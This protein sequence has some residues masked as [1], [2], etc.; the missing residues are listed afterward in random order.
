[1]EKR[2]FATL[3]FLVVI[4]VGVYAA[5]CYYGSGWNCAGCT[6]GYTTSTTIFNYVRGYSSG[7]GWSECKYLD[8]SQ[9]E[10]R[11]NANGEMY[12]GDSSSSG[13]Q[14]CHVAYA[15]NKCCSCSGNSCNPS[16]NRTI[17]DG[18]KWVTAT[19]TETCD[20]I[21]NDC[22]GQI[23]E[24]LSRQCGTTDVGTCSYGT[25]SCSA[26]SWGTCTGAVYPGT[27]VCDNLDN[28]CDGTKD[29]GFDCIKGSTNCATDCSY[30]TRLTTNCTGSI[31]LNA[32][33]N[34][35]STNGKFTQT[36]NGTTWLPTNKSYL[37]NQ[38]AQECAWKC[39]TDYTYYNSSR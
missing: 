7:P 33:G 39:E 24:S 4:T 28:D 23:D 30:A 13:T 25:Q 19:A 36:W 38:T 1:M 12:C 10:C 37:Y 16:N 31:P 15:D 8:G 6:D 32:T 34:Y 20:G 22:D 26:G 5:G 35:G 11:C 14:S 2:L 27:E 17:C 29:D 3:F 9:C 18:C 21:D